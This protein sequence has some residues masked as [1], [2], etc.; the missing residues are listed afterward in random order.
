MLTDSNNGQ[1]H[2]W[3]SDSPPTLGWFQLVPDQASRGT[4]TTARCLFPFPEGPSR[5]VLLRGHGG[6]DLKAWPSSIYR[7][8]KQLRGQQAEGMV[9]TA[10]DTNVFLYEIF[11]K[12]LFIQGI[13]IASSGCL[14]AVEDRVWCP[15]CLL[16]LR[17]RSCGRRVTGD[18]STRL[19]QSSASL[20]KP[21]AK[22][23]A[24]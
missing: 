17:A 21:K 8:E 3:L 11:S 20:Q 13:K 9:Q 5:S 6:K 15:R 18:S 1:S 4:E 22:C 14:A 2:V 10:E 23:T 7:N 16:F 12:E 19:A 24:I